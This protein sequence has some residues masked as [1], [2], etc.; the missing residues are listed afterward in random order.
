VETATN[1]NSQSTTTTYDVFCRHERT[2]GALSSFAESFYQNFGN[3]NTQYAETQGPSPNG[4]G[5][6][7]TRAYFDGLGRT[8]K[9]ESRGPSAGQEILLGEVTFNPRG[10]VLTSLAP[11]Y[12]GGTPYVTS[13]EYD[14]LDRHK[15]TTLPDLNVITQSYGLRETYVTNPEGDI[16]GEAR[17]E[18]GLVRYVIEYLGA[19][20]S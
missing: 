19:T 10:G 5:V 11:R 4:S 3:P 2:D 14:P 7:W 18:T 6:S 9:R 1:P 20:P 8:Y 15:K 17:N 16:T 13:Y 12:A